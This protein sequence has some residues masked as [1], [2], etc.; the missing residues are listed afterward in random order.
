LTRVAV[1]IRRFPWVRPLA[2]AY[3]HDFKSLEGFFAGNPAE[4]DAWVTALARVREHVRP[5]KEIAGIVEAQQLRRGA[6]AAALAASER[7]RDPRAVAVV[8]GQQAGLFGGPL[9]TLLKSLTALKLA[10]R[11][12]NELKVP[13]VA[14][15]WVDAEDHDWE[16]VRG[17]P[18]L[19]ADLELRTVRLGALPGAGERPVG[20]LVLDDDATRAID[21]LAAALSPTEFTAEVIASLRQAYTPGVSMSEAFA[22]LLESM[23]G[24]RGL[25]VFDASDPAAK[26]LAANVFLHELEAPGHCLAL[27]AAAGTELAARGH[28]PQIEP[29]A[30][31]TGLFYLAG[32]RVPIRRRGDRVAVGDTVH[33]PAALLAEA[34]RHPERF[35][36]N[37]LLRPLV[38]DSLF[39]TICYV[40]GP[41][42]L[43]YWAQLQGVYQHFGLPMPLIQPRQ[44]VTVLDSASSRFL[45][46][47][48]L[49]IED[50]QKHDESA[51]NRLLEAQL[52]PTVEASLEQAAEAMRAR[53]N[54]VI[55]AVPAIDPT[56]AGA[57]RTTLGRM[58]H[59]LR[60]LHGKIIHAAKRRDETLRRQF[61]RAQALAFPD[62]HQQER[63]LGSIFFVNRYGPALYERI[64]AALPLDLGT[65]WVVTA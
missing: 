47:Y 8:T 1:D 7:L 37:V 11:V 15:F 42:E 64:L 21:E 2:G 18:V 19:T 34:R 44:T 38:Q 55:E 45:G 52:P 13:A 63:S 36:P 23:L 26:P 57:A 58:E 9:F 39:P 50:L 53:M 4:P 20:A 28:E 5:H 25:I 65:H 41:S 27:A 16:E 33:D 14:I 29:T 54:A 6:P 17:C 3:A 49:A 61:I 24:P 51:L 30:D 10:E 60:T 22:R 40:A 35:S 62:G 31:G 12:S 59:D 48:G 46:R 56:L 32:G 43:A